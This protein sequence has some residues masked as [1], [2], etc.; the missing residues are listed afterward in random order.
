ML[1][2]NAEKYGMKI[3]LLNDGGYQV[4]SDIQFPV[5][6]EAEQLNGSTR[7][8][9]KANALGIKSK[10]EFIFIAGEYEVINE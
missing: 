8:Y 7:V 1:K 10:N 6:V 2:L 5:N 4:L 9:V 3:K